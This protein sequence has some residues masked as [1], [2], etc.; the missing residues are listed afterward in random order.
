VLRISSNDFERDAQSALFMQHHMIRLLHE[1]S[2][3]I[4]SRWG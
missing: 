1:R 3:K 4:S 2:M